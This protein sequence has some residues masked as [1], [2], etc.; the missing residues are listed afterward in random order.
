MSSEVI[1]HEKAT[2]SYD[3]MES[4]THANAA[5]A[6][7]LGAM[8][9]EIAQSAIGPG[10]VKP[11]EYFFFRMHDASLSAAQRAAFA[12]RRIEAK[13]NFSCTMFL[14]NS[15]Q[16]SC[17]G[18]ADSLL[19]GVRHC[20]DP[21]ISCASRAIFSL[22]FLREFWHAFFVDLLVIYLGPGDS[23]IDQK[24]IK[25]SSVRIF[26]W[27]S[28]VDQLLIDVCLCLAVFRR[29]KPGC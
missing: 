19:R 9:M 14:P 22:L 5:G 20:A 3:L 4:L 29:R 18:L 7:G 15:G 28:N 8:V 24:P 25:I 17:L 21:T 2:D 6:K 12:G 16:N 1:F 11:Q 27:S 26:V 23:K 10:K 13:S